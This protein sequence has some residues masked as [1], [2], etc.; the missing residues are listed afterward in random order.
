M[1]VDAIEETKGYAGLYGEVVTE[2]CYRLLSIGWTPDIVFDLGANI[3]I[4]SRYARS[5][6]PGARIIAVEPDPEN[7]AHFKKF[8]SDGN[9]YLIE[10]GIGRGQLWH[11]NDAINGAHQCY[12][13]E[14]TGYPIESLNN[15]ERIEPVSIETITVQEVIN[16]AWTPNCRSILKLD[17]EGNEHMVFPD[18]IAM[19]AI[20]KMDFIA[21][22]LHKYAATGE[23]YPQVVSEMELALDRLAITH[24]CEIHPNHFFAKRKNL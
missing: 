17:I 18:P 5:L 21:M 10:K 23:Q 16:N 2:D 11:F 9:I 6:F 12:L 3:G 8:T 15:S 1:I 4:F 22:E 13:S 19:E 24:D 14:G 20:A 7:C